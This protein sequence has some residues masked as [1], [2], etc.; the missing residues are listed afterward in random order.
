VAIGGV[1]AG[2]VG[3]AGSPGTLPQAGSADLRRIHRQRALN[4]LRPGRDGWGG[5]LAER[6]LLGAATAPDAVGGSPGA[7]GHA[8]RVCRAT[9]VC[10][11]SSTHL[12]LVEGEVAAAS[13][14]PAVY[15]GNPWFPR[16]PLLCSCPIRALQAPAG[17]SPAAPSCGALGP[18]L[19]W[20]TGAG[21]T[22]GGRRCRQ[23]RRGRRAGTRM[24]TRQPQPS[25]DSPAARLDRL[26]PRS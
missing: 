23:A 25:P 19:R 24:A 2:V 12:V 14:P 11:T 4:R 17:P 13:W 5:S 7:A 22:R 20:L 6:R 21:G 3:G 16:M 15:A 10:S 8:H 9:A 18:A 26:R 1:T